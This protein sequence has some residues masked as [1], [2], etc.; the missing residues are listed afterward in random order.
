MKSNDYLSVAARIGH[1]LVE[2][3]KWRD[4]ACTWSIWRFRGASAATE[5]A[6]GEIYQGSSGIALFLGELF[7]HTGE[8][9]FLH[10]ARGAMTHALES[11][12]QLPE[13]HF[14]FYSG[15]VGIA[16]AAARLGHL[17]ERPQFVDAAGTLVENLAGRE[18]LDQGLDVMAG[19]GGAIPALIELGRILGSDLPLD[20]AVNLGEHLIQK[21]CREPSGWSWPVFQNTTHRNLTGFSHG[22]AGIGLAL[23]ELARATGRD[24]YRFAA[25]MAFLYERQFFDETRDNWLDLRHMEIGKLQPEGTEAVRQAARN[26]A[27]PTYEPSFM[28]AWCHGSPG[29]GLSRLR[30]FELTGQKHY[31]EEAQLALRS[32]LESLDDRHLSSDFSLCHGIAGNCELALEAA[33]ALGQPELR[34]LC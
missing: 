23:L 5:A 27:I 8:E 22:A 30:A 24:R 29:I 2:Q 20:I 21:A 4:L 1:R 25:E 34:R 14:G 12:E 13:E 7:R 18:H 6:S 32:T 19:A 31:Q 15:R 9:S 26:G 3:A 33:S 17:L 10:T 16:T 28:T 11:A